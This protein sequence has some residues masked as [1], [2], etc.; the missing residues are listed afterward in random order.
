MVMDMLTAFD[1]WLA[2]HGETLAI[3]MTVVAR[4][5]ASIRL[6]F[7]GI[8]ACIEVLVLQGEIVVIVTHEDIGWDILAEFEC[9]SAA[10]LGGVVAGH[11]EPDDRQVYPTNAALFV[12][13][14]FEP[15][16]G[17][18]ATSLMPA[19][20]LGLGGSNESGNTWAGLLPG[21]QHQYYR[22]ILPLRSLPVHGCHTH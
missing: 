10:V 7:I 8:V 4:A 13:H 5:P 1:E 18:I 14:V 21:D 15:L 11:G 22:V 20:S 12:G 16:A 3:P 2:E 6:R 17:W 19:R 9:A